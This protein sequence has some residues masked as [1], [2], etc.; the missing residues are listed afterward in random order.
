M[1]CLEILKQLISF[2]TVT[3]EDNGV[4]DYIEKLLI[5]LGFKVEIIEFSEQGT[6]SVKN[7]YAYYGNKDNNLCFAGH[8]DV[9]PV[10]DN[11]AWYSNPFQAYIKDNKIYG[12]GVVDMKGAIACWIDAVSRIISDNPDIGLS[13]LLT[14]D[15]EG[16]AING[17]KKCISWLNDNNHIIHNCVVGEPTNVNEMGNMVK[18]GR[19]GSVNFT[20]KVIGKQGHVAYPEHANNPISASIKFLDSLNNYIFDKGNEYFDPT[21]LEITTIDVG[22]ITE[23]IIPANILIK[24]NIRFN[25]E[26]NSDRLIDIINNLIAENL[27]CEYELLHRVSGESFLSNNKKLASLMVSA[28]DEVSGKEA[29]LSTTGGTSDA[30]FIKDICP[31]IEYGLINNTAHQ[32]NEHVDIASLYELRDTYFSFMIL[33]YKKVKKV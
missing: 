19:R 15:E 3:P 26:Y 32:V 11:D 33:F 24:F 28:I 6:L 16:P 22:N 20:L 9:V 31:V 14:G 30:R 10:G 23:N 29:V 21:N 27:N 4:M 12:R 17:T 5:S 1:D 18:V 7:L 8:V 13:F 2:E 25:N